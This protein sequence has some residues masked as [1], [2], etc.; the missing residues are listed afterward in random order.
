MSRAQERAWRCLAHEY[1][2]PVRRGDGATSAVAWGDA[3]ADVPGGSSATLDPLSVFTDGKE[4]TVEIGSGQG[5]AITA[6]AKEN[7]GRAFLAVEV[8]REGLARTMLTAERLH[9]DNLRLI[10]ANAPEVLRVLLPVASVRELW[11]FFPD[12][13]PKA[14][15]HKRRLVCPDFVEL[16]A[17]VLAPGGMLRLATDWG[18]YADEMRD[19]FFSAQGAKFFRPGFSGLWAPRFAGRALT[20]F[21]SK[22]IAAGRDIRDL[23]F[24]RVFSRV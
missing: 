6:A 12:P 18:E 19:V 10:E 9:L 2:L 17:R 8:Y 1:V 14:R 7:P 4:L 13:W 5:H 22:G 23:C 11:I 24:E 21:E 20:A 3:R 16:A 15:H